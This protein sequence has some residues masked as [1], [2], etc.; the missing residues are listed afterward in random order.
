MAKDIM[1]VYAGKLD[2][3]VIKE[4]VEETLKQELEKTADE[5]DQEVDQTE[6]T[7]FEAVETENEL[8]AGIKEM[9]IEYADEGEYESWISDLLQ[10]GCESGMCL[11]TYEEADEFYEKFVGGI[12][13]L[14][15]ENAND[16][17]SKNIIDFINGLY[18]TDDVGSDEQF[19]SLLSRFAFEETARTLAARAGIEI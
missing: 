3:R 17:G 18:G 8:E 12:W 7:G 13:D 15:Y 5:V 14:L 19:K 11:V 16:R 2:S 1:D 6:A 9:I 4:D 10:K